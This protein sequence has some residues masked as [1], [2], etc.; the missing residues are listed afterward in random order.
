MKLSECYILVILLLIM[1]FISLFCWNLLYFVFFN[2]NFS[3]RSTNLAF[4]ESLEFFTDISDE[5]WMIM[6]NLSRKRCQDSRYFIPGLSK[7]VEYYQSH[8][9]PNF[10]C[11]FE[12]S[13]GDTV[14]DGHKWLC[15]P[16]RLSMKQDCLVYSVGSNGQ[17][18]FEIAINHLLPNCEIHVFDPGDFSKAMEQAN[19]NV[20]NYHAWGLKGSRSP[21]TSAFSSC[22]ESENYLKNLVKT[23]MKSFRE[24]TTELGH[25]E[26]RIDVIKIDCEG[27]E[28]AVF[29]DLIELDVRQV[30]MEVHHVC[31]L[32]TKMFE[33]LLNAGYVI[34]HKEPNMIYSNGK[35]VEYSFLKLSKSYH[36]SL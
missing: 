1:P 15:D 18:S 7:E 10:S 24:I 3:E 25:T 4:L 5:D 20:T 26:R 30:L 31:D 6:K 34:F 11:R 32:T 23:N 35:C 14:T 36:V 8:W 9:E 12:D 27:C 19:L 28:L 33:T 29:E 13:I 22:F 21:N 2:P 17:F 16:H